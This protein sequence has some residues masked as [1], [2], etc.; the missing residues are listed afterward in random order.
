[1]EKLGNTSIRVNDAWDED[2]DAIVWGKPG[3]AKCFVTKRSM[4]KQQVDFEYRDISN[5]AYADKLDE[6]KQAGFK[7]LPIVETK[8]LV[9]ADKL[10]VKKLDDIN[11]PRQDGL[12]AEVWQ[13]FHADSI[14]ALA[15]RAVQFTTEAQ[16]A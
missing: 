10:E 1:M 14:K 5:Q 15:M 16:V 4:E 9:E 6:F 7:A 2:A 8:Y 11:N 13:D 3:C 12:A